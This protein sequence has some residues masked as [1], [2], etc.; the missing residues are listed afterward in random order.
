MH[1]GNEI[2]CKSAI[3]KSQAMDHELNEWV[4][5]YS[6][7]LKQTRIPNKAWQHIHNNEDTFLGY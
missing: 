7:C 5:D 2:Y 1:R 6:I 3:M 4:N